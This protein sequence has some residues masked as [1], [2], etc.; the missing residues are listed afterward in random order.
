MVDT[1]KLRKMARYIERH[2]PAK[3]FDLSVIWNC[4][5]KTAKGIT[6][7]LKNHTCGTVGCV[8]GYTPIAFP[9][10]A[11]YA[12]FTNVSGYSYV[13]LTSTDRSTR[14]IEDLAVKMFGVNNSQASYLFYGD[15]T[16]TQ[17]VRLMRE[18]CKKCDEKAKK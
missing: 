17:Q 1:K 13:V 15:R 7:S 18:F 10:E 11:C 6:S 4:R 2:V 12:N 8:M 9:Q 5:A 14:T 3:N 16:K